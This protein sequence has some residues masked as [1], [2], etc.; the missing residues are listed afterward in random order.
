MDSTAEPST[1]TPG[2]A[3]VLHKLR[4]YTAAHNRPPTMQELAASL[5]VASLCGP[6]EHI[7]HL[8]AK[9][10][11][12]A[13]GGRCQSRRYWPTGMWP[14]VPTPAGR[15]EARGLTAAQQRALDIYLGLWAL[16]G[17]R[18]SRREWA[19]A[20]RVNLAAVQGFALRVVAAGVLTAEE[21][22]FSAGTDPAASLATICRRANR[23]KATSRA[24][25]NQ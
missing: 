25:N 24:R 6:H 7:N 8:V 20:L 15:R 23:C 3:R 16:T 12:E 21:M 11:V 13:R 19:A 2:Q 22:G 1:L 10:H 14:T 17:R 4:D 5:G 9:G 18:P